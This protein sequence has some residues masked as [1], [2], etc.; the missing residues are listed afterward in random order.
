MPTSSEIKSRLASLNK[1]QVDLM[2]ELNKLGGVYTIASPSALS[3]IINGYR[4]GRKA[5]TIYIKC[6][7]IIGNWEKNKG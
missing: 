5:E 7:Q 3:L 2:R 4:S 1:K 6:L